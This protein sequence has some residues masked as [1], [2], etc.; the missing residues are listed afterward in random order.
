M[1]HLF[2]KRKSFLLSCRVLLIIAFILPLGIKS[3]EKNNKTNNILGTD[4]LDKNIENDYIIGPGDKL[5]IKISRALP[6]LTSN[7]NIDGNG[8]IIMPNLNRIYVSGLTI[9]ELTNL[10]NKKYKKYILDPSVEVLIAS[11]RP[12]RV[13]VNGEVETP[14]VHTLLGSLKFDGENLNFENDLNIKNNKNDISNNLFSRLQTNTDSP[15]QVGGMLRNIENQNAINSP[16]NN[17]STNDDLINKS[18]PVL[19]FFPTIFDALKKADGVTYFSDLSKVSITRINN[20]SNGGGRIQTTINF[21]D[22]IQNGDSDKNI[23]IYDGDVITI[24]K[25]DI[26]ISGQI[27]SAVLSNLNPKFIPV[28]VTGRVIAPGSHAVTKKS[29]LNDAIVIAGGTKFLKGPVSFIRFNQDGSIDKRKFRLNKKSKRGSKKNPFLKSG[30]IIYVGN[31]PYNI[32]SEVISEFTSP[33]SNIY[34]S[35]RFFSEIIN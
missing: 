23:R 17:F 28:Y 34:G 22:V 9:T 33:F 8:T 35:Y 20:I 13:V 6:N 10:L 4:Y 31:S 30:D 21:L 27:S 3:E 25:T 12:I 2:L 29:S 7:Y 26:P 5:N 1:I 24:A 11:Y 19:S 15:Y 18:S 32:A 16:E 14:G